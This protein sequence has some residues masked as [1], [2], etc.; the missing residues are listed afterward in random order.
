MFSRL[1]APNRIFCPQF[2]C[3]QR[4]PVSPNAYH[5]T[6]SLHPNS[7]RSA[8]LSF[9]PI[10]YHGLTYWQSILPHSLDMPM[11]VVLLQYYLKVPSLP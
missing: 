6:I 2:L 1:H 10:G 3:P 9:L 4:P 5:S 11:I 8:F 7:Y